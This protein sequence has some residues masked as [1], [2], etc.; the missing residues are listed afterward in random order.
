MSEKGSYSSYSPR[1]REERKSKTRN[2]A[3]SS[4]LVKN[5]NVI[6]IKKADDRWAMSCG[7][8]QWMTIQKYH[9]PHITSCF[10]AKQDCVWHIPGGYNITSQV[11]ESDTFSAAKS[12][13]CPPQASS[14]S[15]TLEHDCRQKDIPGTSIFWGIAITLYGD[16]W[17]AK[18][19]PIWIIRSAARARPF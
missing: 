13:V 2:P 17:L 6:T 3:I 5:E 8:K 15:I 7:A 11:P 16:G 19:S 1:K 14:L 10:K 9:N 4:L 18:K 12:S